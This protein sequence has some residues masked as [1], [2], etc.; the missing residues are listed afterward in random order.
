M[1]ASGCEP[2]SFCCNVG[3]FDTVLYENWLTAGETLKWP[4]REMQFSASLSALLELL[5][6]QIP[7]TPLLM[8]KKITSKDR[9]SSTQR[10][11]FRQFW[12]DNESSQKRFIV[13]SEK[14]KANAVFKTPQN[15]EKTSSELLKMIWTHE[16]LVGNSG[17][18]SN[19][20]FVQLDV[21][22]T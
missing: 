20:Q 5:F 6:A 2:V 1:I 11:R 21:K 15:S 10:I 8:I 9:K 7:P 18:I 4:F 17:I 12:L 22:A 19:L 13:G 16:F 14:L 3:H